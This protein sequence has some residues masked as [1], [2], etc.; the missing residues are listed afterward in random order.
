MRKTLVNEDVLDEFREYLREVYSPDHARRLI[1]V[2]RRY[3]YD[4]LFDPSKL[5]MLKQLTRK[6]AEY[7]YAAMSTLVRFLKIEYGI[8]VPIDKELV[9]KHMPEKSLK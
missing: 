4:I 5:P 8:E 2:A 3:A 7:V 1:S 6:T 9:K